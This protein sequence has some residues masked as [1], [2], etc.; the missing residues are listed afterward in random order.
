VLSPQRPDLPERTIFPVV[1]GDGAAAE[2]AALWI[3]LRTPRDGHAG[4]YYLGQPVEVGAVSA[5]RV[6][7]SMPLITALSVAVLR[8][9]D[10][11]TALMPLRRDLAQIFAKLAVL[12]AERS[13]AARPA[14]RRAG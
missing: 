12:E 6:C 8:G 13:A 14:H 9:Q 1:I 3:A 2:A 5:L 4:R 11:A 10:V 7:A